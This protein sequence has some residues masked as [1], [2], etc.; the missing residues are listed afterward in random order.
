MKRGFCSDFE[1]NKFSE[2]ENE[3]ETLSESM[4]KG[5]VTL[6]GAGCG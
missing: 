2:L 5:A 4:K 3:P 6:V 1:N